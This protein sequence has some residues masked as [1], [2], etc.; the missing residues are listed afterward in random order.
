M[1]ALGRRDPF[2]AGCYVG[3][4][5]CLASVALGGCGSDGAMETADYGNLLASPAGLVLVAEEH[6]SGWG[7]PD[8]LVCHEVRNMHV[9]N[10]T[11][12]PDCTPEVQQG[13]IDLA[14]IRGII[15]SQGQAACPQC[16]GDNGVK[17]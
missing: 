1:S 8:C 15:R 7:R 10:R 11:D 2:A 17:P 3:L 6:P 4:L 9:V 14:Q 16:H 12:L 13:C 5:I